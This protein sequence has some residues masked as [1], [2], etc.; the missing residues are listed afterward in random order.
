MVH[1]PGMLVETTT[2]LGMTS[3][4][5]GALVVGP[6]EVVPLTSSGSWKSDPSSL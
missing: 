1:R 2:P 4:I 5:R 3:N 6:V